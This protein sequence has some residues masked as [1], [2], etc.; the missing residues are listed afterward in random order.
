MKKFASLLL[1]LI[2]IFFVSCVNEPVGENLPQST[3]TK[4]S[5]LFSLLKRVTEIKNDPLQD[6]VC[7]DFIYP[8]KVLIYN[9]NLEIIGDRVLTGDND[10]STFLGLLP[11]DQSIS[12]SYP[13]KNNFG[14]WHTIFCK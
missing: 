14:R 3:I 11:V 7:I 10:F 5:E 13:I 2:S 12:I 9:S 1:I 6:V 4:N 8:F